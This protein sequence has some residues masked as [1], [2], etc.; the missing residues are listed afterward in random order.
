MK[1]FHRVIVRAAARLGGLAAFTLLVAPAAHAQ[2]YSGADYGCKVL[3]C[4]SN[5]MGPQAVQDCVAPINQ[6]K[7]DLSDG[8]PFPHC[9][10]AGSAYAQPGNAWFDDC[11]EG[12]SALEAGVPAMI[13]TAE[14]VAAQG[15]QPQFGANGGGETIYTG[16]GSGNDD[17]GGFMRPSTRK[18]CVGKLLG[19]KTII[20]GGGGID[21]G[22]EKTTVNV[23]DHI[24]LF[25]PAQSPRYIDVIMDQKL[26]RRVRW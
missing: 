26:Y 15:N 11:P 17:S 23:Y 10:T 16:I 18:V 22:Y 24:G 21:S 3:L 25:D 13:G 4:L 14:Q 20:T 1:S 19:T 12:T 5:P 8:K 6:L 7:K 9:E 2:F